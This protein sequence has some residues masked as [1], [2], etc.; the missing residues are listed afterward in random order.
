MEHMP[1]D[2]IRSL[3]DSIAKA[4]AELSAPRWERHRELH[5]RIEELKDKCE[6]AAHSLTI[7]LTGNVG[8]RRRLLRNIRN[9]RR[10]C[11]IC[12]TEDRREWRSQ[13]IPRY[14]RRTARVDEAILG[15][16]LSGTNTRRL[17][18]ALAPLLRGAPLSKDAVSRLVGRLRED[19]YN[20]YK[21][22]IIM[23]P[24]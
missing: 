13:I 1:D 7:V 23:E 10:T 18:G 19:E 15:V 2:E 24:R 22:M 21:T 16:Y 6:A 14:Q 20:G 4:E 11:L 17:R 5:G 9:E 8:T 3:R 12:G